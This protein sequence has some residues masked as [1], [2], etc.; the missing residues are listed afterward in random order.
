[1][2]SLLQVKS[3]TDQWHQGTWRARDLPDAIGAHV[4]W[5]AGGRN[6]L[7][8]ATAFPGGSEITL[9]RRIQGTLLEWPVLL[10]ESAHIIQG[11]LLGLCG[12][13]WAVRQCERDATYGSSLLAIPSAAAVR[14]VSRHA[15]VY[16]MADYYEVPRALVYMRGAL[17]VLMGETDGE[18]QAA[19][20]TLAYSRR[21]LDR[22]MTAVAR[23]I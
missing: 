6:I 10:H 2:L 4:D 17:A 21:S 20:A 22:W 5:E 18:P 3:F 8:V 19:R 1:M 23:S 13:A 14:F 12:N 7:G 16:E 11:D 15:S 9:N